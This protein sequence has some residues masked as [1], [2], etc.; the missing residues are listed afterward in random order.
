[1]EKA[2][3]MQNDIFMYFIDYSK[4]FHCVDH[5]MLWRNLQELGIPR[6]LIKLINNLYTNQEATMRTEF[7]NT[8]WFKIRKRV[9][10]SCIVS[11]YLFDL[12]SES[13][14]R[15]VGIEAIQGITIGGRMIN[16]LRYA[17]DATLISGNF[18]NLK[19]LVNTIKET[20]EKV[21]LRL[22]IKKKKVIWQ[23]LGFRNSN[24]KIISSKLYKTSISWGQLFGT[25]QIAGKKFG[26]G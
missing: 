13:I 14:M 6:H 12:Y 18:D 19:I 4:A 26:E 11:P 10:Q 20:S 16:N 21:D 25:M 23:Q 22:N 7:G 8:S 2:R 17:D 24:W 3:E 5:A 9:L 1:M 15:K